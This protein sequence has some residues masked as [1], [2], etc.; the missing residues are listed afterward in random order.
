MVNRSLIISMMMMMMMVMS[1]WQVIA[2]GSADQ[3]VKLWDLSSMT[4]SHTCTHHKDK[5]VSV[6][7][8]P[9]EVKKDTGSQV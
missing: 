6:Q 9:T 2:S 5:V 3:T 1:S 4:C 7:W 8:H